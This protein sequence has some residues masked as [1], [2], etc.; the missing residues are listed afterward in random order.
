MFHIVPTA[1]KYTVFGTK[2]I[3]TKDLPQVHCCTLLESKLP[4]WAAL[5]DL[6]LG[7]LRCVV[8]PEVSSRNA[9]SVWCVL[10]P[11]SP[12]WI[13]WNFASF[14]D[15]VWGVSPYSGHRWWRRQQLWSDHVSRVS[16]Q[17]LQV[18]RLMAAGAPSQAAILGHTRPRSH[19]CLFLMTSSRYVFGYYCSNNKQTFPYSLVSL[20]IKSTFSLFLS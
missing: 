6:E 13:R 16:G 1:T 5:G 7:L 20:T 18:R 14:S 4:C 12:S 8:P 17:G 19:M 15:T 3:P 11:E 10:R 9:G 2:A